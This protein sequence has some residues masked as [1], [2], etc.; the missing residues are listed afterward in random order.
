M[1]QKLWEAYILG[2]MPEGCTYEQFCAGREFVWKKEDRDFLVSY[3]QQLQKLLK[4]EN[5]LVR[6]YAE[7]QIEWSLEEL[8]D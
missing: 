8:N 3:I 1:S 4:S 7:K 5:D 2:E 6:E